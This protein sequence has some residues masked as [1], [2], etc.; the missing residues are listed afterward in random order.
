MYL[1]RKW[2]E[3]EKEEEELQKAIKEKRKELQK[4][5]DEY[6]KNPEWHDDGTTEHM[7]AEWKEKWWV[8]SCDTLEEVRITKGIFGEWR[9]T[10]LKR[11]CTEPNCRGCIV[12]RLKLIAM[13]KKDD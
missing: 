6:N 9:C 5:C 8:Y 13:V 10:I 1:G 7:F 12:G 11:E 2:L 4:E 3:E